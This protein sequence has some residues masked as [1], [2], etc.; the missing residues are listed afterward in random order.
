MTSGN[1]LGTE[2][3]QSNQYSY[4]PYRRHKTYLQ[5][6]GQLVRQSW[7]SSPNISGLF[8]VTLRRQYNFLHRSFL[9]GLRNS[10]VSPDIT[11]FKVALTSEIVKNTY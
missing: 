7:V 4:Q 8:C 10:S 5:L 6:M 11:S 9:V 1:E 2:K 3:I